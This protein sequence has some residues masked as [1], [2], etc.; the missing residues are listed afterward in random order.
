MIL[1]S[2]FNLAFQFSKTRTILLF[3]LKIIEMVELHASIPGMSSAELSSD[4]PAKISHNYAKCL[5]NQLIRITVRF[6]ACD[7]VTERH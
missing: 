6:S 5:D 2:Q 3:T 7:D 4:H 1:H